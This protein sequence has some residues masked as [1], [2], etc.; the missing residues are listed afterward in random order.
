MPDEDSNK[1]K[2]Q[3]EEA[4]INFLMRMAFVTADAR[5]KDRD[6]QRLHVYDLALLKKAISLWPE[7]STCSIL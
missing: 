6:M 1:L 3:M 4:V 5:E 2:S 7:A